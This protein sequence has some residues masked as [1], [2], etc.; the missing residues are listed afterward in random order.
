MPAAAG[1]VAPAS[2]PLPP[3]LD[4]RLGPLD[5]A[6][7]VVSNVI[8]GGIFLVPASVAQLVPHPWAMLA[9]WGAG[10][11][12]AFA[13]AMAYAELATLRPR[14]GGEYVYLREAFGPLAAFLTG[15]TSFVAGFAGAIAASA[16]GLASY[17]GRFLP[18]AG[19]T[20]PLVTL[21]LGLLDLVVSPQAL[22]AISVIATLSGVH[23]L[24]LGPGR[25]VQN[26]LAGTKVALLVAFVALGFGLGQGD[27]AHFT[28]GAAVAPALWVLALIPVM[29][30][31]S[32]WNAAAYLAEEIRDPSRNVPLALGV[33][34]FA[35]VVIYLLLNVLY[36]YALPVA[37]LATVQARVV[38]AVA[39][40]LFGPTVAGPVAAATVVMIAAS[41]SAM[42]MAG[43]RV[44]YAMARDGQFPAMVARVDSRFRTPLVAIVAQ[45]VWASVLVLTGRFDQ[46][47]EYTGFA[48]VLFAG[49]AVASLFVLRRRNPREPRPFRAW[50]YPVAPTVF[51][52]ASL[53]IV[54]S[55]LWRSPATSGAG[56]LVIATGVPI[57]LLMR[58]ISRSGAKAPASQG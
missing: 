15:W 39:D 8:G 18:V 52:V 7:I 46:L 31:Y 55:A 21:P 3:A 17:L 35:V 34:T 26:L 42:V 43:P 53:L 2:A 12:L 28:A 6:A 24:G 44:Y 10:G 57:Y 56:L 58:R 23:I 4:R 22:V 50:G 37:E 9:V 30:S 51:V 25:I 32:G 36:V 27:T 11:A 13:G 40:R 49:V 5:G 45:G 41:I 14:A 16:V 19:D 54:L 33:G 38:D 1:A 47:V 48:V 29:F 20:T